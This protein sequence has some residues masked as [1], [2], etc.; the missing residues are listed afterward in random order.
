MGANQ[1]A[2][3][4]CGIIVAHL[5]G[6]ESF[7]IF[8]LLLITVQ[9]FASVGQLS[10]GITSTKFVSEFRA[11]SPRHVGNVVR[12]A[13]RLS[14]GF[15]LLIAF[16][17]FLFRDSINIH[18]F[19]GKVLSH[20]L[21]ILVPLVA[22][23]LIASVQSSSIAGFEDYRV[24]AFLACLSA[25]VTVL[26]SAV[27]AVVSG[28]AGALAGIGVGL[29]FKMALS[30]SVLS[31]KLTDLGEVE[32]GPMS[33]ETLSRLVGYALP[34]ALAGITALPASWLAAAALT[35]QHEGVAAYALYAAA[36]NI[37]SLILFAPAIVTAVTVPRL[38]FQLASN[39]LQQARHTYLIAMG[40]SVA[41]LSVGAA[42]VIFG[43]SWILGIFGAG[44]A[45]GFDVLGLVI[46]AGL[47][48]GISVTLYSLFQ[49]RGQL[50]LPFLIFSVPRD[51]ILVVAAFLLCPTYGAKGLGIAAIV[52]AAYT[53]GA[54][55]VLLALRERNQFFRP[56]ILQ[57]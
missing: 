43:A 41:V 33:R 55:V 23:Q 3:L 31:R 51:T 11:A 32:Q 8:S 14:L 29:V 57:S 10:L 9:A 28:V 15:G 56:R 36:T 50:W 47:L 17:V 5:L 16:A 6:R 27:L 54:V 45:D 40:A 48:E 2:L 34:A 12:L 52:S 22:M 13:F 25:L 18:A 37:K 4:L 44:F 49:A 53:V 19:G 7:G 46:V 21:L 30:K 42:T 20:E 24:Q 1:G 35:R 38:S 26:C 39:E